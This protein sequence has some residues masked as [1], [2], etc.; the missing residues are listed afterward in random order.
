VVLTA[1]LTVVAADLLLQR[2]YP[3]PAPLMEVDDGVADLEASDPEILLIGSSHARSFAPI[4]DRVERES[5]GERQ[6]TLVSLEYGKLTGY[7][8]VLDHRLRPLIEEERGGQLVR[9]SLRHLILVTE[10]W[11]ACATG[12]GLAVNIPARAWTAADFFDDLAENGLTAFNRNFL[13]WRWGRLLRGSVLVS[14]R[15]H[16]R[17]HSA[18]RERLGFPTPP[19]VRAAELEAQV[20]RWRAT[21][22]E[23]ATDPLCRDPGEQAA[24]EHVIDWAKGR[25]LDVTI[26]LFPRM[27]V[28]LTDTA[29]R[30]TLAHFSER[31]QRLAEQKG[32]R[33]VDYGTSTPLSDEHFMSDFD[34]VT[35]E[36]NELLADWALSRELGFLLRGEPGGAQPTWEQPSASVSREPGAEAR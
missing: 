32:V 6:M 13:G 3:V 9:P 30:T 26:L 16:H 24:L 20:A 21:T 22:E 29:R 1:A 27:P 36:G 33:L 2:V 8:W 12:S 19:E 15:G 14:D 34:H 4:R 17:L 18:L 10:W 11:D 35:Q 31:I 25:G 5:G 28:T 23:G 7:A